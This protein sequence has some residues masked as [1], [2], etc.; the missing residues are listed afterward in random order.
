MKIIQIRREEIAD[1]DESLDIDDKGYPLLLN[2]L[3]LCRKKAIMRQ[4]MS[5]VQHMCFYYCHQRG[6]LIK[7]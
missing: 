6:V 1:T 4:F 7:Y 5:A 3:R 2:G